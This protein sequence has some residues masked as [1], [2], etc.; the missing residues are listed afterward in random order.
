MEPGG[1]IAISYSAEK[2]IK[3][4]CLYKN[5]NYFCKSSLSVRFY[6]F[7][8]WTRVRPP[9]PPRNSVVFRSVRYYSNPT[10]LLGGVLALTAYFSVEIG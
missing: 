4:A 9:P 8:V 7:Y 2:N 1:I 6:S 10:L 5:N 3:N